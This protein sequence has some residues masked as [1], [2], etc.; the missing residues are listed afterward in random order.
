MTTRPN[1]GSTTVQIRAGGAR[2]RTT[3]QRIYEYL[4][5]EMGDAAVERARV[6]PKTWESQIQRTVA[7]IYRT[8]R[9]QATLYL[10]DPDR[11]CLDDEGTPIA[12]DQVAAIRREYKR[13]KVNRRLRTANE[14]LSALRN[15]TVWVWLTSEG[16]R[17]LTVPIHDQ[18]ITLGRIDAQEVDDVAAWRIRFPVVSDPYATSAPTAIALIT[19][20]RAVWECGPS[21]WAGK[22]IWEKDGRNPFGRIPVMYLRGS[23]PAPG[24]FLVPV[25]EDSLD[26]QRAANHD[27]T[28]MGDVGRKQAY[29][30][31]VAKGL[32]QTQASEIEVGPESVVGIPAD[33]SFTFEAPHPEMT[34][35]G[36]QL[37]SYLKFVI[38]CSGLSPA[39]VMQSTA[40]T[41]LGKIV[42]NLDQEIERK[43]DRD[44]FES[45]EQQLYELI[46]LATEIR[47]GGRPVLPKG[48]TLKVTH[49]EPVMPADPIN[50]AQ[51][52][53]QRID[54]LVDCAASIIATERAISLDDAQAIAL[55]NLARQRE[56]GAVPISLDST[57]SETPA[58]DATAKTETPAP[59]DGGPPNLA[60]GG[61]VQKQ[62]LNGAQV[63]ELRGVIEAVAAGT[64]PKDSARAIIL[65]SYPIAPADVDAMLSPLDGFVPVAKPSPF[66]ATKVS[67]EDAA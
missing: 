33:A 44:E 30:Q 36:G 51:A 9:A 13:M 18:W 55:D 27:F 37:E 62:A 32:T 29:S 41:A 53:K 49:R 17:L 63:A 46:Q 22:G 42:E 57:A 64:L 2:W 4:R 25:P 10:S 34:A 1:I 3:A 5:R 19:K 28:M 67:P 61:E 24:E 45:G 11:A 20:D 40:I 15:A 52:K 56:L 58:P 54:M 26:S 50:D 65:A 59:A 7:M 6:Y 35:F 38:A 66:G 23:D 12:D 16:Y 8:S 14:H 39:T 43:R 60:A 21:G 48:V 47:N 31:A